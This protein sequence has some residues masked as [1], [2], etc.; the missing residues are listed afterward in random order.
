M[1]RTLNRCQL[2]IFKDQRIDENTALADPS[3]RSATQPILNLPG[4]EVSIDCEHWSLRAGEE[5]KRLLSKFAV[6]LLT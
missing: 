1:E 5:G 6:H 3:W 4:Q 2:W